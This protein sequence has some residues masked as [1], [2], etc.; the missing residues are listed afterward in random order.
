MV[1]QLLDGV[2]LKSMG[3]NS[4]EYIHTVA[5]AIEL[6]VADRERY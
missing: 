1:L 5:Q 6:V 4:P 3:H 2:D